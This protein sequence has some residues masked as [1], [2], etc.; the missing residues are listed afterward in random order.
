[1]HRVLITGDR[2]WRDR[3]ALVQVLSKLQRAHGDDLL[4]ITG[5]ARG[6]D[7]LAE[8]VCYSLGIHCAIVNAMWTTLGK[9]A[10]PR[11]NA[12]MLSLDPDDVIAFHSNLSESKGTRD[13][14]TRAARAGMKVRLYKG[15]R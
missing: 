4:V 15:D 3:A 1:M 14:V 7:T 5:G 12:A 9:S 8:K 6:A 11:R 2:E 13:M 10:G